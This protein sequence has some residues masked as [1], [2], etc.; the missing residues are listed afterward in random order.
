MSWAF[1]LVSCISP[2]VFSLLYV[3][4]VSYSISATIGIA[5]LMI[6]WWLDG[7]VPMGV[8]GLIP[9][10]AFPILGIVSAKKISESY[11]S[12]GIVICWG[13]LIMAGAVEQYE[14]HDYFAVKL[15]GMAE[16]L[17]IFG[18]LFGMILITGFL[19]MWLSNTATAALMMPISK[20]FIDN[21]KSIRN[22][23][24]E[25]YGSIF[26]LSI[27][28]SSTIGGM[29]TLTGTGANIAMS[30]IINDAFDDEN[31]TVTF[32]DWFIL[33][34]PLSVLNLVVLGLVLI[35]FLYYESQ[36]RSSKKLDHIRFLLNDFCG[37][38]LNFIVSAI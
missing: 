17:G 38:Y 33:A 28:Y 10:V 5:L 26:D 16:N 22:D 23:Q 24:K 34:F 19:S 6:I 21:F 31:C 32:L 9:L 29:S 15:M 18:I 8:T 27:A 20:A 1:V 11:F 30:G 36:K 4:G 12:D 3:L 13:S 37:F 2:L 35:G 14:L 7:H 25:F